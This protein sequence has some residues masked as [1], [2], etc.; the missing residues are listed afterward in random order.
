LRLAIEVEEGFWA[1]S[2]FNTAQIIKSVDQSSLGV[3]LLEQNSERQKGK[4]ELPANYG[5]N[6]YEY[7]ALPIVQAS[8]ATRARR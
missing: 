4:S 3:E 1:G 2:G 7:G 6:S 8:G 5:P